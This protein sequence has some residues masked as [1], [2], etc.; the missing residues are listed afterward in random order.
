MEINTTPFKGLMIIKSTVF[1]DGR[2]YF[3][4]SYRNDSL[5]EYGFY[6]EF[7]QDNES[8]SQKGVL[9][10]LHFQ[11]PPY[12]QAKLVRVVKGKI[13]DV[14]VDIRKNSETYGQCYSVELSEENK[15]LLLV[16]KGFAH[17]FATL[18][19][20]TIV[21]Y[22]CSNYYNKESEHTILWNDESLGID[23]KINSPI[24]SDKDLNGESF[25]GFNSMF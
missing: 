8:M 24:L 4:E 20:D 9:R 5:K 21:N 18:Q 10:G 7:V 17:G 11:A 12:A 19:D 2:G 13:L 1:E 3:F 25:S 22:K 16:P 23:W 14:V 15:M 6:D